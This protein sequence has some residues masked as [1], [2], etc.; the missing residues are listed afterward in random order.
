MDFSV[1]RRVPEK[2]LYF[3]LDIYI[4]RRY[5]LITIYRSPIYQRINE[6][7]TWQTDLR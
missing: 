6:V 3:L 5:N 7:R 1:I 2:I 4:G